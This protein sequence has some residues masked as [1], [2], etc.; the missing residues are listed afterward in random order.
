[1]VKRK[2]S[3]P[4]KRIIDQTG[5]ATFLSEIEFE[6]EKI[7]QLW[8]HL[9]AFGSYQNKPAVFKLASTQKTAIKTQNEYH[10]NQAVWSVPEAEKLTLIV[11][12]NFG[13]GHYGKLFYFICQWFGGK[14]LVD[15]GSPDV[16]RLAPNIGKV[17]QI[18]REIMNLDFPS[19]I[20][21]VKMH[22]NPAKVG[23]KLLNSAREWASQVPRNLDGFLKVIE[24]SADSLRVVPQHGDFVARQMY[25]V[26]KKIGLIDGEHAGF[27]GPRYYDSAQ[28]YLRTRVDHQAKELAQE[29]LRLF[30]HLLPKSDQE[31]FWEE[32]KPVL[33]QRYIGD[34]WGGAKNPDKLGSLEII[35]KEI[36]ENR[37]I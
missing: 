10:W 15:Y 6:T 22:K 7:E 29:Y 12:E 14:P 13:F 24:D 34:L 25:S 31:I 19:K 4:K 11:P 20:A 16:S 36:L 2:Y 1:M 32:L 18:S 28:F 26:G 27:R 9:I 37:I 3:R 33:I 8:R 5:V 17:A 30:K 23:D 21:F 35:G